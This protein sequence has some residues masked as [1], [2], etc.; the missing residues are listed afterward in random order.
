MV[1]FAVRLCTFLFFN[2]HFF[3]SFALLQV[4]IKQVGKPISLLRLPG[5]PKKPKGFP[6]ATPVVRCLPVRKRPAG[7]RPRRLR[8]STGAYCFGFAIRS[9]KFELQVFYK[10]RCCLMKSRGFQSYETVWGAAISEEPGCGFCS[11][12]PHIS[13]LDGKQK[14]SGRDSMSRPLLHCRRVGC[15]ASIT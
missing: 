10:E 8:S 9:G 3:P 12:L 2:R 5:Q 11:C 14:K 7:S 4:R 13:C 1:L 6:P 15:S